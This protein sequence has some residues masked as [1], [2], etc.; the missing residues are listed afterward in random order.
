MNIKP[1]IIVSGDPFGT[2]YEIFFKI[3]KKYHFAKP[4]ILIG[5]KEII[6][7]QIKKLKYNF[8][9]NLINPNE[10]NLLQIKKM[11]NKKINLIDVSLTSNLDP[12]NNIKKVRE[13]M[14]VCF[15]IGLNI[16]SKFKCAGLINGPVNKERFL[17]YKYLGVTEY[18][19]NKLKIK[20]Y[21]MLIY[22][23]DLSVSPITTHL[24]LK[25]VNKNITKR[26]IIEKTRLINSF[27]KKRLKKKPN[28]AVTGLNPHCESPLKLNEEKKFIT[29]AIKSLKQENISVSGP[30]PADTL[31]MENQ[32]KKFDVIIG[33]Y[34]D[35]V[36]TPIKALYN[37]EAIN[38]TLGLP[39][40]RISPD[41]GP[42]EKMFGKN[43]SNPNSLLQSIK[44]LDN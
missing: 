20:S 15:D 37:F 4:I 7:D 38:I 44:F 21:A 17:N 25:K 13:Y 32:I 23:K 27:Y 9:I 30:Y 14:K 24:P 34:H 41:H 22:N 33:M 1:I 29:P 3:K 8:S 26:K 31:F 5:S 42:N 39:F 43:S 6:F 18:L 19:A 16:V 10:L 35:Q 40:I 11:S 2:F 28:I 12:N 36:L